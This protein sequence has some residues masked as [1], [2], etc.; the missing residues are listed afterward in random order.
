MT[1]RGRCGWSPLPAPPQRFEGGVVS[2]AGRSVVGALPDAV[3][4]QR[5]PRSAERPVN[6]D[7]G[8][9]LADTLNRLPRVAPP[10]DL[11][12]LRRRFLLVGGFPELI[13]RDRAAESDLDRL[14]VSQQV[15]RNDAVERAI[16]KDIPQLGHVSK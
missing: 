13:A 4:V 11:E 16:Y 3:P 6:V 2:R 8:P 9:T 15:L 10:A 14:L 7:V 1:T 12:T 5:I